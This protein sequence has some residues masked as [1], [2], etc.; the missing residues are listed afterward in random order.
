M[1]GKRFV[2]RSAS[3]AAIFEDYSANDVD[4]CINNWLTNSLPRPHAKLGARRSL[5]AFGDLQGAVDSLTSTVQL[6]SQKQRAQSPS[7]STKSTSSL[8]S[9]GSNS[10]AAADDAE[11]TLASLC[12]PKSQYSSEE[13]ITAMYEELETARAQ[14][15]VAGTCGS[16][17]LEDNRQLK[18]QNETLLR[19]KQQLQQVR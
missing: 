10:S 4:G 3:V 16:A 9:S 15:T 17:L 13:K 7:A 1:A 5:A 2:E 6:R 8:S 18:D 11:E 14:L 12:E 19:E